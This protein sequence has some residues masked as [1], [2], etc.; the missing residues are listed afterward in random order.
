MFVASIDIGKHSRQQLCLEKKIGARGFHRFMIIR[1][2]H[3]FWE[4]VI[5]FDLD[6]FVVIHDIRDFGKSPSIDFGR[7]VIMDDHS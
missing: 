2:I 4:I 5:T 3:D 6:R 1:D 7:F